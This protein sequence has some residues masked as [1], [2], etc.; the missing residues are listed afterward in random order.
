MSLMSVNILESKLWVRNHPESVFGI[1]SGSESE[2][3][4]SGGHD[5][6]GIESAKFGRGAE[7]PCDTDRLYAGAASGL[8]I[9]SGVAHVKYVRLGRGTLAKYIKH[10]GWI[11]LY[12]VVVLVT[13]DSG[14]GEVA[15][16]MVDEF[17]YSF[18]I[19]IGGYGDIDIVGSE[20]TQQVYNAGIGAGEVGEMLVVIF[21][22][23][24]S[25]HLYRGVIAMIFG[26]H[27]LKEACYAVAYEI[28]VGRN[29]M[30]GK[31]EG[32]QGMVGG[33]TEVVNRVQ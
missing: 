17:L 8:H 33:S 29:G 12:G 4:G 21:L 22:E 24:F 2:N 31:S 11:G 14:P 30:G 13:L 18:L 26:E 3:L 6:I 28:R 20:V 15:E 9:Y 23:I 1:D 32:C 27:T 10:D 5:M 19:F 25:G 16:K 7:S